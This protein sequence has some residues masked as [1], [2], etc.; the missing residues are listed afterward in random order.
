[1][2]KNVKEIIEVDGEKWEII[3]KGV[4]NDRG[5]TFCHLIHTTKGTEQTNG[6]YPIQIN[7]WVD[8]TK[9]TE[10]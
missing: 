10:V 4:T 8:L 9:S 3:S 1:M 6:F 5:L 7:D 2:K